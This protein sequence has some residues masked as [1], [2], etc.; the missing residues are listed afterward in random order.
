MYLTI[1]LSW[2]YNLERQI[3]DRA[4]FLRRRHVE[5]V[6]CWSG[7]LFREVYLR[8]QPGARLRWEQ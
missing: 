3:C 8:W 1:L 7:P 4:S 2:V 6:V 5:R